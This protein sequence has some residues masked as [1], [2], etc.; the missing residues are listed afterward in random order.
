MNWLSRYRVRIYFK[1]SIWIMPAA[2]TLVALVFIRLLHWIEMELGLKSDFDPSTAMTLLSTL[3]SSMFTLIVFACSALLITVQLASAQLTPRFISLAFKNPVMRIS[4]TIFTFAFTLTLTALIR[5]K[6]AVPMLTANLAAYSCL[7]SLWLFLYLV[8]NVGKAL[9]P[10]G[11]LGLISRQGIKVISNV[12]P[13]FLSEPGNGFP[14]LSGIL[15]GEPRL[16]MRN[17]REGVVL[18]FNIDGL[19]ALAIQHDCLI[20]MMPQV[21]DFVA[22][23]QTLF[24]VFGNGTIPQPS[25]FYH[26]VAV[27]SE[28][29]M[30]Q[31]PSF[32]FRMIVDIASKGLSPAIN[33]PTTAVLA[34][35][36][37][38]YLLRH[39]G[40]R[41]LDEGVR[42]DERGAVR[43]IY[44][45]P[46]W[47][48]FV[49][50]AVT[51][52]RHF[53]GTSIQVARRLRAM[54]V[55]LVQTLPEERASVL[56]MELSL[57]DRSA[58]RFFPDMEDQAMAEISD[59]QGVGGKQGKQ[60]H[61]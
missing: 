57:L 4:L 22:K 10:S 13:R 18:A 30:E 34:I 32:S 54:L 27:G 19:V 20:E 41:H 25:V 59:F 21:G 51:E 52:V 9:R 44:R 24:R 2:G 8:D 45:T 26:S 43:L 39:L 15:E 42:R 17:P 36:Q 23:G 58:K 40:D 46:D 50:L 49:Q 56:R 38:H 29:T 12:Y 16:N 1:D 48:D 60:Q 31:D 55:N 7:L 5:I 6:G 33:D 11:A 14:G 47:E 61:R 35:D 53:G 28:R 3:A 37:L